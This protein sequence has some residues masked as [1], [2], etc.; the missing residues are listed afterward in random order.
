MQIWIRA[1]DWVALVLG[2]FV[3]WKIGSDDTRA[4]IFGV[5]P[6]VRVSLLLY[7]LGATLLV[8]HIAEPSPSALAR[9]RDGWRRITGAPFWG[10]AVRAFTSTRSMVLIVGFL[11]V[12]A[13]G[14]AKTGFEPTP[15]PFANLPARFDAGWYGSVAL[16]GYDRT[17]TFDQQRNVAF[18]PAMP[19][20]MRPVG[21]LFGTREANMPISRRMV[22][23][24]WA[25][26]AVSLVS[27]LVALWYLM[28]LGT[29][30]LGSERAGAA[31]LLLASYPFAIFY[32]A[33][34]TESL[35]LLG[36]VASAF[37]FGRAQWWRAG[38]W[39]LLVGLTRPNGFLLCVPLGLLALQQ[40]RV[41]RE[42]GSRAVQSGRTARALAAAAMPV[43]GMLA[44]TVYL[45]ERNGVWFAW[46]KSHAAWGRSYTGFDPMGRGF[47]WLKDEG[48][49]HVVT[50][51]PFDVLNS[52]GAAF[53]LVMIWPVFK[54]VGGPWA[55][56]VALTILPPMFAGGSLSLGRIS[57]TL[58]P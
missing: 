55:L 39:G 53:A 49:I 3:A 23:M 29:P 31:V 56:Y 5:I 37:H 10:P 17:P 57:S 38:A 14:F 35:F 42:G 48:L 45:H 33:A 24:L 11:A 2:S 54:H 9:F 12:V 27:F 30:L 34:Y 26:V 46:S 1:A 7:A 28:K 52:L 18:F 40:W 36:I 16:H 47:G 8:R 15:N 51:I 25:G 6:P 20:L 32:N 21:R 41:P 50:N 19:M 4:G 13:L 44:F 43:A 58:F 22:R